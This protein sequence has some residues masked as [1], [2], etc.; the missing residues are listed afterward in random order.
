MNSVTTE[1]DQALAGVFDMYLCKQCKSM[2]PVT[3]AV[4]SGICFQF[5]GCG[6]PLN[7]YRQP[8]AVQKRLIKPF[9]PQAYTSGLNLSH[10]IAIF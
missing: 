5:V 3:T 10:T 8:K 9:Q 1:I 2:R 6:H 7:Y 4:C